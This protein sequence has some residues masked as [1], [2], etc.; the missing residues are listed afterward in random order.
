MKI[1]NIKNVIFT[2]GGLKGWAYIGTI[3]ALEELI[4]FEY[5]EN[6]I[7]VSIGSAFGLFYLLGIS[8]E[9]LLELVMNLNYR[10]LIDTQLDKIL[11]NES[12]MAGKKFKNFIKEIISTKIDPDITFLELYK[13]SKIVY[14]VNALNIDLYKIDYFNYKNTPNVKVI[15]SI[16][17]SCSIPMIFP[18]YK[19]NEYHYY[20]GGLCN[21]CPLNLTDEL[22]TIA[23]D[24]NTEMNTGNIKL[25]NLIYSFVY[26]TN[27]YYNK[28]NDSNVV[29][30]ILDNRFK[31]QAF[32]LNQSKDDIF[33][34]YMNGYINSRNIIYNNFIALK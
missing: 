16:V 25:F 13:F 31:D 9:Y 28:S 12:I 2:G 8:H 11:I 19:I 10:D 22:N 4:D 3:Q 24:V 17:A 33:N 34:I 14:T 6:V 21:N 23:F 7:G 18:P 15:D 29:F 1:K 30:Q 32:N 26:I 27:D 5:L 20:D